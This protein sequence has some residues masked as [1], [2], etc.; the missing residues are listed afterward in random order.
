MNA[1]KNEKWIFSTT[2]KMSKRTSTLTASGWFR[3]S[4]EKLSELQDGE[5]DYLWVFKMPKGLKGLVQLLA[6]LRWTDVPDIPIPRKAGESHVFY[7]PND[8]KSVCFT[9]SSDAAS[10]DAVS[11]W[12]Q[13]HFSAAIR[14]NF[15]GENGQQTLRSEMLREN[16][17]LIKD[18]LT[19]PFRPEKY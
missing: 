17:G 15:Q 5:T 7:D 10:I 8:V 9:D 6:Q 19:E 3:S 14:G 2:G 18:R 13:R 11:A 12:V 16:N 1:K 4:R